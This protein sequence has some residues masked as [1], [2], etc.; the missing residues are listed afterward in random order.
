M[1]TTRM[2]QL[3]TFSLNW[4]SLKL[5]LIDSGMPVGHF[6]FSSAIHVR[7]LHCGYECQLD[8]IYKPKISALNL[9]DNCFYW[10][11]TSNPVTNAQ[12]VTDFNLIF[13]P[14]AY[15]M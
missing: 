15:N 9:A 3:L 5:T 1:A 10:T 2:I 13:A 14:T 12:T 11:Q 4:T 7:Y 6:T 8:F